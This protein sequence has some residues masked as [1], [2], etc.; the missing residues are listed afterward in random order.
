MI[1]VETDHGATYVPNPAIILVVDHYF[2][3][4][5]VGMVKCR[6]SGLPCGSILIRIEPLAR[7]ARV[8]NA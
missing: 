6:L 5:V 8:D 3:K 1:E 7:D 4:C 2:V